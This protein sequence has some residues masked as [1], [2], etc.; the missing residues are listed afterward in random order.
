MTAIATLFCR[1]ESSLAPLLER[2][3]PARLVAPPVES[4]TN[5]FG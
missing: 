1:P 3:T 4:V 5:M 2:M